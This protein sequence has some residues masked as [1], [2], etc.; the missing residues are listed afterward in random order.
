MVALHFEALDS[1]VELAGVRNMLVAMHLLLLQPREALAVNERAWAARDQLRDPTQIA[2]LLLGRA[3]VLMAVGRLEEAETLLHMPQSH[4]VSPSDFHR[5]EYLAMELARQRGDLPTT[6]R[7]GMDALRDWPADRNVRLRAWVAWRVQQAALDAHLPAPQL[8][9]LHDADKLAHLLNA[10]IR[11]RRAG[12]LDEADA[13]Y[14]EA[15]EFAEASGVPGNIADA[16]SARARW[17]L[18]RGRTE[19]ASALIGRLAPWA[20]RDFEVASLQ[21]ALH[22]S[23]KQPAQWRAALA[24]ARRLAGERPLPAYASL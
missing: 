7:L 18:E 12:A 19:E 6:A 5:H 10:A 8:N 11:H 20:E 15:V 9:T 24:Q 1:T 14:R 17:L 16:V 3:E 2:D 23:L 21:V 4:L 22:R 13:R